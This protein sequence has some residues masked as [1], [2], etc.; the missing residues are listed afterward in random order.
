MLVLLRDMLYNVL[1]LAIFVALCANGDHSKMGKEHFSSFFSKVCRPVTQ[2]VL[3]ISLCPFIYWVLNFYFGFVIF[4]TLYGSVPEILEFKYGSR[5]KS[6]NCT[7]FQWSKTKCGS[8]CKKTI[9][10]LF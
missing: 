6:I 3:N 10:M 7:H 2:K 4:K 8:L 1:N 5:S 9:I